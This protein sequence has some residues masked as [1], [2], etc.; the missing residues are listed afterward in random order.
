[1]TGIYLTS[2]LWE[3]LIGR[4]EGTA[5]SVVF[6]DAADEPVAVRSGYEHF[7]G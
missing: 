4:I 1:M 6:V 7:H 2:T 5:G 3:M